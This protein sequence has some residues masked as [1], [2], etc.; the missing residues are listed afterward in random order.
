MVKSAHMDK[1][2]ADN[3]LQ[4]KVAFVT[5]GGT[6]IT[7]GVAR[8]MA[9]HAFAGHTRQAAAENVA[10]YRGNGFFRCKNI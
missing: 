9:E 2:F 1:I 3:I 5:G 4:G 6:G 7:A 8:A 10:G